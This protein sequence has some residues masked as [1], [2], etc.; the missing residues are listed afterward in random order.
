MDAA[1]INGETIILGRSAVSGNT[2]FL[3]ININTGETVPIAYPS[4]AGVMVYR[5]NSGNIYGVTVD[6]VGNGI[7]TT[8]RS[9]DTVNPAR[10][11]RMVEFQGEDT[12]FSLAESAGFLASTIGGEGA[13]SYASGGILKF[14]R[15]P[16]LPIRIIEG[17]DFF[18]TLD[19]EGNICW[20]EP[21][22]G[23]LL[24][25]FKLYQNEWILRYDGGESVW[26]AVSVK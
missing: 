12:Q 6:Q 26:G 25:I 8:I 19:I 4:Q 9:L 23:R 22:T 10:S 21:R 13:S 24:A 3:M 15:G 2:P 5:G 17:G 16:G 18:I 14:D 7:T 20:H 11:L 1:F